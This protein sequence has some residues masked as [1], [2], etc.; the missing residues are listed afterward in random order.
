MKRI[1][2]VACVM[3]GLTASTVGLSGCLMCDMKGHGRSSEAP[4]AES[5]KHEMWTCPMHPEIRADQPGKCPTCGMDL[6]KQK[7]EAPEAKTSGAHK[8]H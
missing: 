5:A 6:V 4:A 7:P 3:V 2:R 1:V 8:G